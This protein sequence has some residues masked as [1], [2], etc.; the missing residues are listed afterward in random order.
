MCR[1][2]GPER[3]AGN[4]SVSRGTE[5]LPHAPKDYRG[6][7][8]EGLILHV[9]VDVHV[10]N[11]DVAANQDVVLEHVDGRDELGAVFEILQ[12]LADH[13]LLP[14]RGVNFGLRGMIRNKME[15]ALVVAV[16]AVIRALDYRARQRWV[17]QDLQA[18]CGHRDGC[19]GMFVGRML[20]WGKDQRLLVGDSGKDRSHQWAVNDWHR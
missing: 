5:A 4:R 11:G 18:G 3:L 16:Q 12:P 14:L 13:A 20:S 19:S 6:L 10:L 7:L 15:A 8:V 9:A 2:Q 1:N 17:G